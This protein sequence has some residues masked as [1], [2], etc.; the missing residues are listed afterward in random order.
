MKNYT[1]D[2]IDRVTVFIYFD[3]NTSTSPISLG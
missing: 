3:K 2:Q 1:G